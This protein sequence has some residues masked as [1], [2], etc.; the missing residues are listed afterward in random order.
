MRYDFVLAAVISATLGLSPTAS[1]QVVAQRLRDD[2]PA[3]SQ[4]VPA[5]LA[6]GRTV[7]VTL[8][9]EHLE[10]L[11]RIVGPV[12]VKIAK[13]V[14]IEPKQARVL[15]EVA[16]DAPP[17]VF[18]GYFLGKAGLSNP[19]LLRVDA[20][21]QLQEHEDNNRQAEANAVNWPCGVNGVLTAADQDWF[22]FEVAA[23]QRVVF[24]VLA[25]RLGSPLRPVLT[26]FDA[27]GRELEQQLMAP[28]DIAPDNRLMYTFRE[29]GSYFVR[30]RD[31]TYA[32]ADF[33]VYQLRIGPIAFATALFPLGGKRGSKT[34]VTF[35]GGTL[36]QPRIHELDLTADLPWQITRLQLPQADDVLTAPAWFA[37][38]DLPEVIEAEPNDEPAQGQLLALPITVNGR[39]DRPSDQDRFRLHLTAGGKLAVRVAAQQLGS[40]LD[41]IV[42]ITD[43]TGKE[44]LAI[45]DRQPVPREPPVVRT[46]EQP[47]L[48][49]PLGEFTAAIEGDYVLTIED[50]FNHGGPEYGYR[51]ELS[52]AADFE[53]VVQPADAVANR[54]P[55]QGRRRNGPLRANYSGAGSGSLSLDRGGSGSLAVRAF[56]NGYNGPIELSVEGLPAGVQAGPATIA[57]GQNETTISLT[58]DFAAVSSASLVRVM[59]SAAAEA[60]APAMRRLA[61]QPVVFS[62]LPVN[63]GL[64]RNLSEIAVGISQQGAELA[65][66]ASLAARLVPG[67]QATARI[68]AQ[69]RE[70]YVGKIELKLLNL[71]TGLATATAEIAP[72][73][74][75]TEIALVGGDELTP[76]AHRLLVEATMRLADKKQPIVAVFPLDFEVLPV[77]TIELAQ[78]QLDLPQSGAAT[79]E[80]TVR[81][82][83]AEPLRVE[84]VVAGLPKGVTTATTTIEPGVEHFALKLEAGEGATPSPIR[85]IIQIKPRLKFGDRTLDSPTLR[86][87]LRLTKP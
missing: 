7:E 25:Q 64:Q 70:G 38:G 80:F 12:G 84:L 8:T 85:R 56:R 69:R 6:R 29:S 46:I 52:P 42:T 11:D 10:G 40:P 75:A 27:A 9:G 66:H 26:L 23:G 58:A 51:L 20:W 39:I 60:N 63:G 19:K 48:D 83:I 15:L 3:I 54:A 17:G 43:S 34:P 24:D 21:P 1:A 30:L 78:Q 49:D 57:G 73:L 62:A 31:L 35:S 72:E 82:N 41:A 74:S 5:G 67:G 14:A 37:L 13:V 32:G 86:F 4:L 76:G 87:A 61:V 22:R 45:D 18:A 65:I 81:R 71:P 77:A 68:T 28:R 53:L 36:D 2:V 50:R 55:P 79:V 33:A 47:L 44:L 16:A 59:G